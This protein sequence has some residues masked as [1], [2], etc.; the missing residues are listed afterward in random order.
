MMV[1]VVSAAISPFMYAEYQHFSG[2]KRF[3]SALTNIFEDSDHLSD[4][5]R[6]SK[7]T[8]SLISQART[9][10]DLVIFFL[11]KFIVT[12]LSVTLPLPVGLFTPVF[13][14]G[15]VLGRY[16]GEVFVSMNTSSSDRTGVISPAQFALIGSAAF[17]TGVTRAVSTAVIVIELSN[18]SQL[19]L[20]LSVAVIVAYF[21]GN[22]LSKNVY[23]V[24]SDKSGT[25]L[26]YD[27]PRKLYSIPASQI[28]ASIDRRHVLAL[29]S[30]YADALRLLRMYAKGDQPEDESYSSHDI[31]YQLQTEENLP[32]SNIKFSSSYVIPVVHSKESMTIVGAILRDDIRRVLTKMQQASVVALSTPVVFDNPYNPS[33]SGSDAETKVLAEAS[34]RSQAAVHRPAEPRSPDVGPRYDESGFNEVIQFVLIAS[35]G[36]SIL[37]IASTA[38]ARSSWASIPYSVVLDPSPYQIVDTMQLNKVSMV[39]GLLRLNQAYV[40]CNGCLVGIITRSIIRNF[41]SRYSISP[42]DRCKELYRLLFARTPLR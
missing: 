22:R 15:G 31:S 12:V 2:N 20:P 24:L 1:L 27:L 35:D 3:N 16:L 30:T 7:N 40:T 39:F 29:D 21:V 25:P 38:S 11:Y 4:A 9:S 33:R 37:P 23:D 13:W 19:R 36:N 41:V 26:L 34:V 42:I 8:P 14:T 6:L 5:T 17:A 32:A 18:Q 10:S 28:M